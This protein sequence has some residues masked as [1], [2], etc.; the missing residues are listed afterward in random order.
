MKFVDVILLDCANNQ[1]L[2]VKGLL[3]IMQ[4]FDI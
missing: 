1:F 3:K 2:N 4:N